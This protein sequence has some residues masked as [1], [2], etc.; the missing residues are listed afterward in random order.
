VTAPS[1]PPPPLLY[2][3][4][5]LGLRLPEEYAPWVAHD[6]TT[7]T[8]LNWRSIRRVVWGLTFV[9]L[10]AVGQHAAYRWP[11]SRPTLLRLSLAA[12]VWAL[13]TSGPR[14]AR[15]TLRWQRIDKRGNPVP[16]RGH[17]LLEQTE[18]ALLGVALL[19][20]LTGGAAAFGY[21]LR[22]T[23]AVCDTPSAATLDQIKAGL[24]KK[25]ATIS[26]VSSIEYAT[27]ELVGALLKAPRPNNPSAQDASLEFW[28]V[29]GGR[30][31]TT[32]R[33]AQSPSW[34]SF[35]TAPAADRVANEA[36]TRVAACLSK[37]LPQRGPS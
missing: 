10:Y 1:P 37:Q 25:D 26:A 21:G 4:R 7:K 20:A 18:A 28:I 34:S 6:V 19:I 3:Y 30:I 32:A 5:L 23:E 17:G 15:H 13:L 27:G 8:F 36:V 24:T 29:E 2:G 35:P 14:M 9:G 31:Y 16:P 33:N 12:I 22:P 11:A